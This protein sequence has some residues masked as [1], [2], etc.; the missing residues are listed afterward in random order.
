MTEPDMRSVVYRE[1]PLTADDYAEAIADLQRAAEQDKCRSM[2]CSV[3]EDT[4]HTAEHCH[5]NPLV[6][7][8]RRRKS[9]SVSTVAMKPGTRTRPAPISDAPKMRLRAVS[10][11][12]RLKC[13]CVNSRRPKSARSS[14]G[15]MRSTLTSRSVRPARRVRC[16]SNSR[17]PQRVGSAAS[18]STGSRQNRRR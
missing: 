11:P 18:A 2:C 4:G 9:T 13:S 3:C 7:A 17:A 16:R 12:R 10:Q 1:G 14:R 6:L 5:H 15:M 8:R